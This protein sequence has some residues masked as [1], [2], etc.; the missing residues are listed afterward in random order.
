MKKYILSICFCFLLGSLT[1]VASNNFN[2]EKHFTDFG[3][4]KTNVIENVNYIDVYTYDF[5][6]E[7]IYEYRQ[8]AEFKV[9]NI[10]SNDFIANSVFELDIKRSCLTDNYILKLP[11]HSLLPN[12]N[13]MLVYGSSIR[14]C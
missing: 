5:S 6:N 10:K 13:K 1:S 12:K 3:V 9:N 7:F 14:W 4:S 8:N 2:V 11:N